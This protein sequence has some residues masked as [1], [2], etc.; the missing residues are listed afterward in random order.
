MEFLNRKFI[1]PRDLNYRDTLFGGRL[2][3]WID[4]EC[5][6]FVVSKFKLRD[7]ATKIIGEIDFV[8]P[9]YKTDVI[10]FGFEVT[11]IGKTSLVLK[12]CVRNFFTKDNIIVVDKIVMVCVDAN[13]NSVPH[14]IS[15]D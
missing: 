15:E 2:L 14:G 10:E 11:K 1:R 6:V 7:I 8:K 9:A 13:N 4:E 3:R 12:S 5:T